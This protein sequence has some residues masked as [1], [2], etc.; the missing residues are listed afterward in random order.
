MNTETLTEAQL[1]VTTKDLREF[2]DYTCAK[3]NISYRDRQEWIRLDTEFA[4]RIEYHESRLQREYRSQLLTS[5]TIT[6]LSDLVA[7]INSTSATISD[8]SAKASRIVR[9]YQ[10]LKQ[11]GEHE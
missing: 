2:L 6:A 1:F 3:Y 5:P 10:N 9:L 7:T 8:I 4:N 11:G